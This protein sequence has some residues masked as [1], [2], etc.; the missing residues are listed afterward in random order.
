MLNKA[1]KIPSLKK[2]T[3]PIGSNDCHYW[4]EHRAKKQR[5]DPEADIG[6][7]QRGQSVEFKGTASCGRRPLND[8]NNTGS[9]AAAR[10]VADDGRIK[11]YTVLWRRFTVKKHKT[12]DGDGVLSVTGGYANL[13]D[14]SGKDLGKVRFDSPLLPG[15]TLSIAGKD[16]EVDSLISKADGPTGLSSVKPVVKLQKSADIN[17]PLPKPRMDPMV[18][19][20]T[21]QAAPSSP[22][23]AA[24]KS[25]ATKQRFKTP[26]RGGTALPDPAGTVPLPRH[27]PTRPGA[28]VM[29]RPDSVSL[30]KQIVDVVVDPVLSQHLREHQREGVKF[31][32]EC[33]MGLRPFEGQ[34]AIL[35]DEMGLGKTLQTIALLWTL[36]KQNPEYEAQPVIKKALVVCPVTL[37]KNWRKEFRKWLG[38]ERIG[39][40]VADGTKTNLRDFTMGKSYSVM[41]IGYER[42]RTVADELQRGAGIDI[43]IADEGHRLK[44]AQ[45]KSAQAIKSLN[46]D[47]RVILSGTPI[48]NDLSEFW[49]MVD[50]VN[51]GLLGPYN[52]FRKEFEMTILKSRQPEATA[53]DVEKGGVKSEELASITGMFILRRT[54]EILAKYL[55]S[56]TEYVLFCK[57]TTAQAEIYHSIISSPVFGK[58]LGSPEASLQ[59]ITALQKVCNSPTL[60]AR[61][62]KEDQPSNSNVA[63]LLTD[64]TSSTCSMNPSFSSAKLCVL[65]Q[66]LHQLRETTQEKVVLVSNYT[67]TLDLLQTYLA[68][69]SLPFLRLDG[70][71]PTSKR[72]TLVDDFNRTPARSCFAFLLSAKSGGT[73]LNL[74]GASRLVLFEADWN[75]STDLQ[76]MA[77]IHRDG[78]KR[79]VKIYRLLVG[80]ALDEKIWQRQITKMGLAE[81]VMDQGTVSSASFSAEELR[82]LF[83]LD[84]K[85][86]CQTHEL[87][88]C[89]CEGNGVVGS[90]SLSGIRE[91]PETEA[92]V[93]IED[94]DDEANLPEL[95]SLMRASDVDIDA[96]ERRLRKRIETVRAKPK[97]SNLQSLM[98]YAHIDTG[99]L[100]KD[101]NGELPSTGPRSKA[102]IDD[103]ILTNILMED[104]NRVKFVFAKSSFSKS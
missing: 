99:D 7:Y 31:M 84:T 21:S 11:Y 9:L 55:P 78:Q 8:V 91:P 80:G 27:D 45:N 87:I 52:K 56:K 35:A 14:V 19:R 23:L 22:H 73:G 47:R 13:Q 77:R 63:T 3:Q 72:Q 30:G 50:F 2:V 28:L 36:L 95:G 67:S 4:N 43:V 94:S 42:L 62:N 60:L 96:Q 68:A 53:K 17:Q 85:S 34:G 5:A 46:T 32:Y 71:T 24:P 75:P 65:G 25:V 26:V 81:S 88:G 54:A 57:P 38:M 103:D 92:T 61:R 58:V 83:T 59:L 79:A 29:K 10:I 70:S 102:A 1:F 33:V 97:G 64:I 74:I 6:G 39:V 90:T 41:I 76:A 100:L 66:L 93:E 98:Q 69:R 82:D 44:T 101:K 18:K 37:I 16:V 49:V 40:F 48:Q 86:R 104:G 51:S 15:S 89:S 20:N 12:W